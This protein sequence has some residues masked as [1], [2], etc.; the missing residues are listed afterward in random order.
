MLYPVGHLA[1]HVLHG[2]AVDHGFRLGLRGVL[3]DLQDHHRVAGI[4]D[5]QRGRVEGSTR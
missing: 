3:T 4:Q 1:G 5:V 2:I